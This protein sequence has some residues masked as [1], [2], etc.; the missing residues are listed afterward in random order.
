MM[1]KVLFIGILE[2][3]NELYV[4]VKIVGI[5]LCESYNR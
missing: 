1:E 2:E 4:I 3:I 5:K